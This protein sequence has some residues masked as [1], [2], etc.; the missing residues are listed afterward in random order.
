VNYACCVGIIK[1]TEETGVVTIAVEQNRVGKNTWT[2]IRRFPPGSVVTLTKL[3][4]V[5]FSLGGTF[6]REF[7]GAHRRL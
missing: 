6:T 4:Q 7:T 2:Y 5:C 1:G 3:V